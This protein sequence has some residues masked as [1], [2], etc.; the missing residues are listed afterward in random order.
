M[1][2]A[3]AK[4]IVKLGLADRCEIGAS[5]VIGDENPIAIYLNT[6]NTNKVDEEVILEKKDRCAAGP[7]A[8]AQGL[9]LVGIE[10]A[11]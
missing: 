7:T 1:L 8:P 6:F 5:Y 3:I 10:Y 2:R 9:M 4:D 11:Q